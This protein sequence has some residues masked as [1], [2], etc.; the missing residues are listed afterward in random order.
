M[1]NSTVLLLRS[2]AEAGSWP[3]LLSH[4]T[5]RDSCADRAK[6]YVT[7]RRPTKVY[8]TFVLQGKG[9]DTFQRF[10]GKR[11]LWGKSVGGPPW[12]YSLR[13]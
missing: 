12:P 3:S 10:V 2:E 8:P 13:S 7:F 4:G 5:F 6:G 1:P 9:Y 11:G